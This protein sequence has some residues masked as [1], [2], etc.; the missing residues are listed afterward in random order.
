[1]IN[2]YGDLAGLRRALADGDPQIKGAQ[3]TRLEAASAY[4]DVAP[5]VVQVALDAPVPDF[6]AT[7]PGQV[8]DPILLSSL[9]SSYGLTNPINR[10]LS[11]FGVGEN[12]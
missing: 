10:V 1:L 3:R 8:G 11:A 6:D 2:R 12:Y 7:L 4:L 5:M 9:A